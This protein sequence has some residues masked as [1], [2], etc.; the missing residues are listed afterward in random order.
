MVNFSQFQTTN[1]PRWAHFD[2]LALKI[3]LLRLINFTLLPVFSPT[4]I[5]VIPS[6]PF[7]PQFYQHLCRPP[8]CNS[9]L[10]LQTLQLLASYLSKLELCDN[11]STIMHANLYL[12][13]PLVHLLKP[14]GGEEKERPCAWWRVMVTQSAAWEPL[15]GSVHSI[16]ANTEPE[17]YIACNASLSL[18]TPS[19]THTDRHTHMFLL[20]N[21]LVFTDFLFS[22]C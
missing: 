10:C 5:P 13:S 20:L 18:L 6:H 7:F 14:E 15:H 22:D 19:Q 21:L 17:H 1:M 9:P 11:N 8:P 12:F 16:A 2:F 3:F 4:I